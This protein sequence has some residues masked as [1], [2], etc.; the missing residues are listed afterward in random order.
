[1]SKEKLTKEQQK[2][3]DKLQEEILDEAKKVV[4]EY[5]DTPSEI[6]GSTIRIDYDSSFLDEEFEGEKWKKVTKPEY[7]EDLIK[8]RKKKKE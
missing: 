1:M 2:E 5:A 7:I 3:L 6:S 8:S 4:Q